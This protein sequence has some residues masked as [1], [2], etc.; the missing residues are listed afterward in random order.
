MG[1]TLKLKR[2]GKDQTRV[3]SQRAY[4]LLSE[5]DRKKWEIVSGELEEVKK[6][7]VAAD[8]AGEKTITANTGQTVANPE[9][10]TATGQEAEDLTALQEEYKSLTGKEP[11]GNWKSK[12]LIEEIEK[13]KTGSHEAE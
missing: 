3:M 9:P 2:V 13:A 11:K 10:E 12:R 6:K 8:D 7:T 5:R 1:E 4:N